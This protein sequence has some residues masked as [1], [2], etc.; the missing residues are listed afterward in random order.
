MGKRKHPIMKLHLFGNHSPDGQTEIVVPTGY[1]SVQRWHPHLG[2]IFP[3]FTAQSSI[4]TIDFHQWAEGHWVYLF[5]HPAAFTPV[6]STE[7]ADVASRKEELAARNVRAITLSRDRLEDQAIWTEDLAELFG[8]PI[9]FPLISDPEGVIAGVC[10]MVHPHE[11]ALLTVRKAFIIDPAL[12][13]R[14]IIEYPMSIGRDIEEVL[15]VID[16]LQATDAENL[17]AP[18]GWM[19]GDPLLVRAATSDDEARTRFGDRLHR[20]RPY[21]RMVRPRPKQ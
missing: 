8:H 21:L 20:L 19:P 2:D 10:G 7:L 5:S 17:A 15:R 11:D 4:G 18:A 9:D 12:R 6:C 1:R 14:M 13:I 16:A 3:D